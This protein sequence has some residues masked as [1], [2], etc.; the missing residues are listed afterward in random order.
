MAAD[1]HPFSL[2]ESHYIRRISSQIDHSTHQV[3]TASCRGFQ[4]AVT[5]LRAAGFSAMQTLFEVTLDFF[6][7]A[8]VLLSTLTFRLTLVALKWCSSPLWHTV[9]W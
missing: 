7:V 5:A 9:M 1:K 3:S 2:Q 6:L 4:Y 8:S